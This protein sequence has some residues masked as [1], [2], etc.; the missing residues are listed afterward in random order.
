M[1]IS[2]KKVTPVGVGTKPGLWTERMD[3]IMNWII[4]SI[5]DL[6]LEWSSD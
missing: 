1:I 2:G 3:W 4:N 6:I 5:L